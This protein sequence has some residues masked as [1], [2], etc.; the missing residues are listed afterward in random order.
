MNRIGVLGEP[1]KRKKG[2]FPCP[3]LTKAIPTAGITTVTAGLVTTGAIIG[4]RSTAVFVFVIV[5]VPCLT[6]SDNTSV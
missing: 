2:R 6:P 5:A 4:S 3:I 1:P